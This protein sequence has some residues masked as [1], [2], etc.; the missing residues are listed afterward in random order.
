MHDRIG[1]IAEALQK[2]GVIEGS[3][4]L[5]F[6]DASADWPCSMLAIMRLG[7]VY[8]P[9]DLRNPLPRLA[10]VAASCEPVAILVDNTTVRNVP[11]VNVT[12]GQVVNISNV[13]SN[14]SSPVPNSACPA[15]IAAILYTSGSTGK[16]KGIM[17]KHSGLRNEIEGY[18]TTWGLRAER[19]LQQSAFTF[20]HSSDQMY[21]GLVN[22]GSVYIVPWSKRGDPIEVTK[23]IRD[24]GITYTKATPAEYS[25]WLDYG[26]DNLKQAHDWRFAFGGGEQL[27]GT[28]TQALATLDLA[29]LRFFNS[30]GPTEISISSTKMEVAY[31]DPPPQGRLPCGYSLPNYTAYILDD[32]RRPVPIGMPGELWIGGA[33]VSLGYLDNQDLTNDH[34]VEDP[35]ATPEYIA[36]GWTRMYRTGDIAHL[37]EDGAMVFHHRVAGD[38]QVKIRG[39]RIELGDI[40]SNIITTAEG[41]LK[42]AAVTLRDSD[43]PFLVAH[44]VF[45]PQH[46]ISDTT[47]FLQQLLRKLQ[48]PQYM[49]PVMAIA[50]D[51]M[52]LN[53]HSKV[54]RRALKE[55]SLP[56]PSTVSSDESSG[57]LQLSP[58]M[59]RLRQVWEAVLKTNELGLS[60]TPTTDF[61]SIGGNSLLAVRLQS[62]ITHTFNVTLPLVD[63][64]GASALREMAQR[65]E[66]STTSVCEIDW[67]HETTLP[68]LTLPIAVSSPRSL[69]ITDKVVLITGAGGFLGKHILRQ[70]VASPDIA[71]I[72][73]IGLRDKSAGNTRE[74][75]ISSPKIV[76]HRG[77]LSE[78]WLGLG[79]DTF[80]KLAGEIDSILHM[81][82]VRSFWDNY[83]LLYPNNVLPT[84][85]LI[86]MAAARLVPL[87]YISTAGVLPQ[88]I[89]NYNAG[90]AAA[91]PPP[92]D[93]SNGYTASRWASERLLERA[94]SHLDVPVS[95]HRFIPGSATTPVSSVTAALEHFITF[96]DNLSLMP[97][98]TGIHGNFE[99]LPVEVAAGQ[100][101]RAL[102]DGK[103]LDTLGFYHHECPIR[104]DIADMQA[105]LES[106]R[107]GKGL[108]T[109]PLLKFVGRMKAQGL[110]Y[111][112]TSQT[113]RMEGS[114]ED[115]TVE[116]LESRR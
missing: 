16:P 101:A 76:L 107:G 93:G 33:G 62:R 45:V 40:E 53:N 7:A 109:I 39:L 74:L 88:N 82:A 95:I 22:G 23:I 20:N 26:R 10:D 51:R 84:K 116:I 91:Y 79:E 70:L 52:P 68:D 47:S 19:V 86:H 44:V 105:F 104:I 67:E 55:L 42:E 13:P 108:A 56:V 83:H 65:I 38:S 92:V 113:L 106:R 77:D 50:L 78:A 61:F 75:A 1:A 6:E 97:D 98:F 87:H 96:V 49:V 28:L 81:A 112:I 30:Y 59:I 32:Q 48:V 80:M 100:L 27:T 99:M 63:L 41:V 57:Q 90:S 9:L 24:E 4:V 12:N 31:R 29:G 115:G 69:R 103:P 114:T 11:Y 2:A 66:E 73:C 60:I 58:T 5:V 37:Q 3:R 36:Q 46:N 71:Q 34:F 102:H 89:P 25:L 21:T 72:H 17:V 110:Q 94:A 54:D 43:P 64:L 8:V 18:T 35:Y 15:S 14:P 111:F 85:Q